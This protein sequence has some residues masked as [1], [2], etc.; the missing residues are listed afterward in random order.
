[1]LDDGLDLAESVTGVE[2]SLGIRQVLDAA[3]DELPP[4]ELSTPTN[5]RSSKQ[6]TETGSQVEQ[7]KSVRNTKATIG[8][9]AVAGLLIRR[10]IQKAPEHRPRT[11][12]RQSRQKI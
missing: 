8:A 6:S 10:A 11:A 9:T 1:V 4:T 2:A 12:K 5:E 7:S 3:L